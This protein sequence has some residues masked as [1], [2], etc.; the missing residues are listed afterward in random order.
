M[1]DGGDATAAALGAFVPGPDSRR[2]RIATDPV[3]DLAA[4]DR[5][6]RPFG[7]RG[8][9]RPVWEVFVGGDA[10]LERLLLRLG[11]DAVV[12][13]PAED[14]SLA[15]EAAARILDPVLDSG[16]RPIGPD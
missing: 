1:V 15:P 7:G 12:V 9:D 16:A 11:P 6:R 14:R 5:S 10:W 8:G 3:D 2:V 4:R 13:E